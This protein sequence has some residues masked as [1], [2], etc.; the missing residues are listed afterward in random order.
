LDSFVYCPCFEAMSRRTLSI[1]RPISSTLLVRS[2]SLTA[3][4]RLRALR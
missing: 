1:T 3:R 2:L 4:E